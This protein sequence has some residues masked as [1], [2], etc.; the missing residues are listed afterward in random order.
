MVQFQFLDGNHTV[1]QSN[2]DNPCEP[3][4]KSTPGSTGFK[5]GFQP[6]KASA[7]KGQLPVFTIMVK[8]TKPIWVFCGQGPHCQKGMAMV[9]NQK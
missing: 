7:D 8:D 6:V 3:L 5:S 4:A 9:I 1:T 2:F